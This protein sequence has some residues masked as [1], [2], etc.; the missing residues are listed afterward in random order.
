MSDYSFSKSV[1]SFSFY[2]VIHDQSILQLFQNKHKENFLTTN[3]SLSTFM[4]LKV[5]IISF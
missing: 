1:A 2:F 3:S 5:A 4:V